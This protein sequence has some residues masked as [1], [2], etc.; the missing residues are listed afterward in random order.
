MEQCENQPGERKV[1]YWREWLFS[2]LDNELYRSHEVG[3]SL[4]LSLRRRLKYFRRRRRR[5]WTFSFLFRRRL[6]NYLRFLLARIS[7]NLV[8][9]TVLRPARWRS[10]PQ[11]VPHIESCTALHQQ[12]DRGLVSSSG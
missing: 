12:P 11:D 2:D 10:L 7:R 3:N 6:N 8:L 9:A 4:D 5:I 1:Y